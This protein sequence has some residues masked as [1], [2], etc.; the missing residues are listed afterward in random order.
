MDDSD[1]RDR[2][3]WWSRAAGKI[4]IAAVAVALV[5]GVAV[6]K[7]SG[8]VRSAFS[9]GGSVISADSDAPVRAQPERPPASSQQF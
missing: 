5:A 7:F 8:Q 1:E 2:L 3:P 9:G 4:L 6:A